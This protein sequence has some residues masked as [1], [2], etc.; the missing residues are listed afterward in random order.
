MKILVVDDSQHKSRKIVDFLSDTNLE[1]SSVSVAHTAVEARRELKQTKYDLLVLDLLL[2]NRVGDDQ[3]LETSLELLREISDDDSL[4]KPSQIIGLTAFDDAHDKAFLEFRKH[5]WTVLR[6]SESDDEWKLSLL[7]CAQYISNSIKREA[8]R[9]YLTDLC[10]VTALEKPEMKAIKSLHWQWQPDEPLDDVQFIS[11]GSFDCE[12]KRYSAVATCAARMGMVSSASLA[13]KLIEL[14]RPR[15]LVMTGICAGMKGKTSGGDLILAD[16]CW[17]WQSGKK[18]VDK[19]GNKRLQYSGEHISVNELVRSRFHKMSTESSL[20]EEIKNGYPNAPATS[21]RAHIGPLATGSSV[22]AD[23]ETI[24]EITDQHR[25]LLG[26]EMEIY[27]VYFASKVASHPRPMTF[28]VKSVCDFADENK[29]D[30]LQS[31]A[32]Y[33]SAEFLRRYFER[34]MSQLIQI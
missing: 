20:L 11:R 32:A 28:A 30:T 22:L 19:S 21:L 18:A 5:S 13:T 7:K 4:Y 14:L 15:V 26:V 10:I 8:P 6:F 17:D 9:D 24:T 2:P 27:G 29:D 23:G 3:K 16:P 31:Y 25:G 34:Y 33:T 12:G 1:I